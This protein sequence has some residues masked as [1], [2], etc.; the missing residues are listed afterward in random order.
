M[1]VTSF[2]DYLAC[3]YRYYLRHILK[4]KPID[5]SARELAANQFG[6][7]VHGAVEGFGDSDAKDDGDPKRI[8]DGLIEHLHAYVDR[9]Y[10][11]N[12]AVSVR[13]QVAQATERLRHV[14]KAQAKRVAQG[15]RTY[16]VEKGVDEKDTDADGNPKTPAGIMIDD[17]W[18]GLRGR[19]DRIDY[20]PELDQWAILDFKTHGHKP[21]KKH[22]KGAR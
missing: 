22:L 1:S 5:D 12:V 4:L 3:P 21:E 7:L 13:L 20:H 17:Q 6:D 15:W 9:V 11:K 8:E 16:A 2:R 19:F 10:G 14:A 18:M